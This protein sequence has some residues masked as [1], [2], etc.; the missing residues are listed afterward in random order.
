MK[1]VQ[2]TEDWDVQTVE[3]SY[4]PGVA[5]FNGNFQM[6]VDGESYMMI[7]DQYYHLFKSKSQNSF[8]AS[9]KRAICLGQKRESRMLTFEVQ[10]N[11]YK[12][13]MAG[14]YLTMTPALTHTL[15]R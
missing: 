5:D 7:P 6:P 11:Y 4:E 9:K 8:D 15:I 13:I 14:K 10:Y 2:I 1:A 12:V 3:E